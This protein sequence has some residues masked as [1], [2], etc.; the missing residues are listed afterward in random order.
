MQK[1][2]YDPNIWKLNQTREKD[3]LFEELRDSIEFVDCDG[4]GHYSDPEF[5]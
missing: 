4:N 1:I 2:Y 3:G 5:I